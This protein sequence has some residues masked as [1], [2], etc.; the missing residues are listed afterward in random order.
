MKLA[1]CY[2]RRQERELDASGKLIAL[3]FTLSEHIFMI[4]TY[5]KLILLPF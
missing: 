4:M 1:T 5:N 2:W 3:F